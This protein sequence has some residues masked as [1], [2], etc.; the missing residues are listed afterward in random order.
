M[1]KHLAVLAGFLVALAVSPASAQFYV[2]GAVGKSDLN[3]KTEDWVVGPPFITTFDDTDT[4]WKLFAGYQF[5]RHFGIEVGYTD[6]G[7]YSA[8]NTLPG[9]DRATATVKVRSVA[10]FFTGR[11][12]VTEAFALT[13]K[14]GA[15]WNESK[16]S[17]SSGAVV[18][19][20][21]ASDTHDRASF[22]WGLGASY[23]FNKNVAIRIEYED[24]GEAGR[25]T[26]LTL[27][28]GALQTSR[29]QPHFWSAGVQFSF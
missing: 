5:S 8:T 25:S 4:G 14:L 28:P 13:G 2:G 3:P 9:V 27:A 29:S 19:I 22:A 15:S 20:P 17:F 1:S 11:V 26:F 21:A 24:F 6:L 7:S 10:G 12:P 16:M 23:A 18:F